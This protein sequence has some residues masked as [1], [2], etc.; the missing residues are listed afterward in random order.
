MPGITVKVRNKDLMKELDGRH[1]MIGRMEHAI[2]LTM[3]KM[4]G[5]DAVD[6]DWVEP[7]HSSAEA[8]IEFVV[9]Y[10]V[11]PGGLMPP[12]TGDPEWVQNA[13]D[14]LREMIESL[15]LQPQTNT[16][17]SLTKTE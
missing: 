10:S 9:Q 5:V 14:E 8:D 11:S 7:S 16:Y 3:K 17:Y 13:A 1:L 4:S 2:I 12:V 6:F 15:F